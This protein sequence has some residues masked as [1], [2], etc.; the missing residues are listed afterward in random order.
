MSNIDRDYRA[1][2]IDSGEWVEG[3]GVTNYLN[4]CTGQPNRRWIWANCVNYYS[5][6][7]IDPTTLCRNTTAKIDGRIVWEGDIFKCADGIYFEVIWDKSELCWAGLRCYYKNAQIALRIILR[8]WQYVG[9]RFD[10]AEL[11]GAK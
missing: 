3:Y 6:V 11:L 8:N 1:K 7:E 9:D 2:R 4:V 10:N 5:W